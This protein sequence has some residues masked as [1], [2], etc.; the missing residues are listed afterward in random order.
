MKVFRK[1]MKFKYIADTPCP[2]CGGK[3]AVYETKDWVTEI[4]LR[5]GERDDQPKRGGR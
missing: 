4:C 1:G 5:C 2:F 3:V